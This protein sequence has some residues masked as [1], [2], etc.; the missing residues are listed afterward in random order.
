[1]NISTYNKRS[2]ADQTGNYAFDASITLPVTTGGCEFGMS[3]LNNN[4]FSLRSGK[5]YD[6][7]NNFISIYSA[8]IPVKLSGNFSPSTYDLFIN[9]IPIFLGRNKPTGKFNYFYIHPSGLNTT[10]NLYVKGNIPSYTLD[11]TGRYVSGQVCTGKIVS[12]NSFLNLRIF[13]GKI[14]Q[15]DPHFTMTGWTTTDT[16]TGYFYLV[17]NTFISQ[18]ETLPL[19]LFTNFGDID[20]DYKPSGSVYKSIDIYPKSATITASNLQQYSS[21]G[22]TLDDEY[23]DITNFSTFTT[24]NSAIADINLGGTGGLAS[25]VAVGSATLNV[26]Y[27]VQTNSTP[28]T[29][30]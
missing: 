29:V 18:E 25:G 10:L 16:T 22:T 15:G 2:I 12:N 21:S 17:N 9:Q 1:M 20:F 30:N 4:K 23:I 26:S 5:I 13:S 27:Q 3:G 24:S 6:E 7:N 14:N 11:T 8:G 28:I 19:T